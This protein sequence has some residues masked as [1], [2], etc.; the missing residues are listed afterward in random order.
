M[1]KIDIYWKKI[2]RNLIWKK[3][4]NQGHKWIGKKCYW[5]NDGKINI[6]QNCL[7]ESSSKNK[8]KIAIIFINKNKEINKITYKKL[9]DKVNHFGIFLER[10]AKKKKITLKNVIINSSLF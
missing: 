5:Y 1:K 3:F 6:A 2:A 8:N 9:A 7:E 10:E 4:P